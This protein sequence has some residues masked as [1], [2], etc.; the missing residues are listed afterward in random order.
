MYVKMICLIYTLFVISIMPANGD[1]DVD[2]LKRQVV[3]LESK[4]TY[5]S[6]RLDNEQLKASNLSN[7]VYYKDFGS[8]R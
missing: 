4:F 2:Q 6:N 5:L 7:Q 8:V 1:A 3:E